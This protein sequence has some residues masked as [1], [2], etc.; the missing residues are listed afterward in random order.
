MP[1]ALLAAQA[2]G[3]STWYDNIRRGLLTSGELSVLIESGVTGVT[4]N[5]TIFEKAITGSTDYDATLVDLARAGHDQ[6]VIFETLAIED[7]RDTADLLRNVYDRTGGKDGYVS[8]EVSPHLAH[9]TEATIAAARRLFAVLNRP[10]VLIKVPATPEGVPAIERLISEGINVNV[11]LIFSLE[12]YRLVMD[13]YLRG[14]EVL[15][16]HGGDLS[17]IASVASFFVSR[18]DTAVDKLIEEHTAG[19]APEL[20]G[21]L[22]KAAIAN[23]R[24]AYHLFKETFASDRFAGLAARGARVQR[25]L[26]AST[27]TKNPLYPDTLYVDTL[28]GPDT[29]NTMPPATIAAV[30][31]HGSPHPAL[32]GT[33]QKA[34]ATLDALAAAGIDMAQVTAKLLTEGVASF[35]QSYDAVL[36]GIGDKCSRLIAGHAV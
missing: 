11:T 35:A 36:A 1:N 7:I 6:A 29:V 9:D 15:A 25:P 17:R 27:G 28:I 14:L 18:V 31:D 21:L 4:S 13:A 30:L 26:W 24:K 32:D 3:Q 34:D 23:A 19:A 12:A 22:G 2:L 8:L 16:S 10:N 20:K 33:L 5:P